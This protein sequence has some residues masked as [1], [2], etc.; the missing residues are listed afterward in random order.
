MTAGRPAPP[1]DTGGTVLVRSGVSS[2]A[3]TCL[4]SSQ[5]AQPSAASP[6]ANVFRIKHPFAA[7]RIDRSQCSGCQ[8]LGALEEQ[9]CE[10]IAAGLTASTVGD[11]W[12]LPAAPV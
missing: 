12:R 3:I 11:Q 1:E 7:C 6:W 5:V 9:R 8:Q 2:R 4:F 10:V